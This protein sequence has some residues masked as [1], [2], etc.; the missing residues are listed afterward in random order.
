MSGRSLA[1]DGAGRLA[2]PALLQRPG[3]GAVIDLL[4]RDGEQARVVGGAVRDALLGRPVADTDLATTAEPSE[5]I[6][7]ADAA[8]LR[9]I[10]TG[11]LHGTVTVLSAGAPIEVTT[12]RR[13]VET[14]GRHA[15]VRFSRDFREDALRRDFTINAL[16]LTADGLVH[17]EVGGLADLAAGRVRFIG[18][19]EERIAEDRLRILRFFRFHAT[20]GEG[21]LDADGLAAVRQNPTALALLSRERVRTELMKLLAAPGAPPVLATMERLGLLAGILG[22]PAD[23]DGFK[24]LAANAA[25]CGC[26]VDPVLG[27]AALT[28]GGAQLR[29]ALRLS[30]AEVA[31]LAAAMAARGRLDPA[32]SPDRND[33]LALL[34][35]FGR[36]GAGDGAALAAA[37]AADPASWDAAR[38]LLDRE[39]PPTLPL[40]GAAVKARGVTDGPLVGATLKLFQAAWIRAGF[41]RD[42]ATLAALLD[43][44]LAQAS[45]AATD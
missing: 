1:L 2:R 42:P 27:L 15:V 13:D 29:T 35:E 21:E 17:D 4:D 24:R 41:P 20:H 45:P 33:G 16:S 25:R 36:Q 40:G 19:P 10:P 23:V 22:G 12:L 30:N 11:I 38:D 34:M 7:R 28:G 32:H 39:P 44:A 43:A 8:G 5:V 14:D 9:W 18:D 6:R 3:L 26:G 31:R 37:A